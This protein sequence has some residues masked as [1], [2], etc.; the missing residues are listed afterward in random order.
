MILLQ[1]GIA[2]AE[3]KQLRSHIV[4]EFRPVPATNRCS[5]CY[6]ADRCSL[7][8]R[9]HLQYNHAPPK[10]LRRGHLEVSPVSRYKLS[11]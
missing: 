5:I 7:V 3:H 4:V 11:G 6:L 10:E 2:Q 1:T 8:R 9:T